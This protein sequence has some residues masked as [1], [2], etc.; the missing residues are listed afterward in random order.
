MNFL[1]A[2]FVA[3]V[4]RLAPFFKSEALGELRP[5]QC[6][7]TYINTIT[8]GE[9]DD[10]HANLGRITLLWS[11]QG[12]KIDELVA[13]RSIIQTHFIL[14]RQGQPYGR[15]HVFFTPAFRA[16]DFRPVIQLEMTARGRPAEETL[17]AAFRLLDHERCT[18]VSD[19]T[20]E[21]MHNKWGR[22]DVAQS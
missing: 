15:L 12:R 20:K 14:T 1:R 10:P 21:E 3:E 22:T 5:N 9:D 6:E 2:R 11:D 19:L 7:L 17:E 13:E 4:E 16:D 18:V 8:L